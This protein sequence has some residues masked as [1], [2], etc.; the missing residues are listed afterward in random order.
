VTSDPPLPTCPFFPLPE[1]A[2]SAGRAAP[3]PPVAGC[4][5]AQRINQTIDYARCSHHTWPAVAVSWSTPKG[6][7]GRG[8]A[9]LPSDNR[10][11]L[12]LQNQRKSKPRVPLIG[13]DTREHA[14]ALTACTWRLRSEAKT[15]KRPKKAAPSTGSSTTSP[16]LKGVQLDRLSLGVVFILAAKPRTC[17]HFSSPAGS[18][19]TKSRPTSYHRRVEMKGNE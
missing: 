16:T 19:A 2:G 17:G 7:K 10:R 11:N 5:S 1:A 12:T 14:A 3:R 18:A 6:E 9:P 13:R 15:S 4:I 8:V